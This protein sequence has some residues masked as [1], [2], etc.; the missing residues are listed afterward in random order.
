MLPQVLLWLLVYE[1]QCVSC[2]LLWLLVNALDM[3]FYP[4][5]VG[6]VCANGEQ[7][8]FDE[9]TCLILPEWAIRSGPRR[10][11]YFEPNKVLT[12]LQGECHHCITCI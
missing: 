1:L 8:T 2:V 9:D 11:V 10:K 12:M 5:T 7:N 6:A 4:A 3:C